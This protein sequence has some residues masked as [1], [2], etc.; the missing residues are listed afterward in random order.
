M[1]TVLG[2]KPARPAVG[3]DAPPSKAIPPLG[4]G[5]CCTG[6]MLANIIRRS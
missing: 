2:G 1:R 6:G 4:L 5:H 3:A